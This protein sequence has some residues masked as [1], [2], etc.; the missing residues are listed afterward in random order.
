[1]QSKAKLGSFEDLLNADAQ[2]NAIAWALR[3]SILEAFPETVEV[4]RLGDGAASYGI[5]Y[6]K[7]SESYVYIMPKASYVNLGFFFGTQLK[8]PEKLLEGTGKKMRHVKVRSLQEA[9]HPALK[10]LV[11]E[12]YAERKNALA[13]KD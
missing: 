1:M 9:S 2:V 6:K 8:D 7:N 12:A 11:M 3:K 10:Q 13:A 4:V 5:G